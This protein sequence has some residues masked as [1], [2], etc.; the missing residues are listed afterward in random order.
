MIENA[1]GRLSLF[2]ALSR[3]NA[4]QNSRRSQLDLGGS[5][6]FRID[7]YSILVEWICITFE[8]LCWSCLRLFDRVVKVLVSK[9]NGTLPRRFKSCSSRIS[10]YFSL[11]VIFWAVRWVLYHFRNGMEKETTLNSPSGSGIL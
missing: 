7:I 6:T 2:L 3:E 8:I 1:I 5:V 4:H 11:F 10:I 9:T